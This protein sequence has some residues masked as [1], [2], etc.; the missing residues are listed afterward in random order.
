MAQEIED[1]RNPSLNEV[2]KTDEADKYVKIA[3]LFDSILK[4]I[5]YLVEKRQQ[6]QLQLKDN[7]NIEIEKTNLSNQSIKKLP[8]IEIGININDMLKDLKAIIKNQEFINPKISI[9]DLINDEEINDFLEKD[10]I[11]L[12]IIDFIKKYVEVT[13]K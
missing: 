10:F 6:Q 2:M 5:V 11:K 3:S 4:N 12:K 7:S 1:L 9:E 13:I 8:D